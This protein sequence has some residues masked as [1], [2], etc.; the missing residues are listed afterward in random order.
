VVNPAEHPVQALDEA[1]AAKTYGWAA[2]AFFVLV[3]LSKALAYGRD[4]LAG[5]PAIGWIAARLAK[6]KT[7]MIVAGVGAVAA[8]GYNILA[9]GGTLTS[10]L[11]AAAVAL[12][13]QQKVVGTDIDEARERRWVPRAWVL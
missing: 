4:K 3:S 7:A 8:A 2:L 6:G 1:K 9:D 5:L 11:F 10:A 13:R 12:E